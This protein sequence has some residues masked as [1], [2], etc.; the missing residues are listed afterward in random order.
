MSDGAAYGDASA[1]T[2]RRTSSEHADPV[3]N[4]RAS[5]HGTAKHAV[6]CV[7]VRGRRDRGDGTG[8]GLTAAAAI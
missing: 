2:G 6:L 1:G 3:R 4:I 7:V 5:K 8:N